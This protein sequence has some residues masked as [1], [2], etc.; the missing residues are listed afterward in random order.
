MQL[1]YYPLHGASRMVS[2]VVQLSASSLHVVHTQLSTSSLCEL[3]G[4]PICDYHSDLTT[5]IANKLSS[6]ILK[7]HNSA[8]TD[9]VTTCYLLAPTT[10]TMQINNLL[11]KLYKIPISVWPV[12]S[13][14]SSHTE[15]VSP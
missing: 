7:L 1:H 5:D 12:I 6:S 2:S 3:V 15:S 8:I 13:D 9:D 14:D 10:P 4:R 11:P